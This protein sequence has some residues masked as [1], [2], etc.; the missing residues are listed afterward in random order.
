MKG[1]IIV[2]EGLDCSGKTTA[3]NQVLNFK[4]KINLK[5]QTEPKPNLIYSKGI[6]ADSNF[7]RL[8]R[9]FPSTFIFLLELL[10]NIY[11]RIIS[12]L[13]KGNIVLQDRY[14]ISILSFIPNTTRWYN[15]L[16]IFLV[17]PFIPK[18]NA[19]VYFH[20]PIKHRIKRLKEKAKKYELML[21][22]NPRLITLRE[23]EYLKWYNQFKGPKIK[24]NTEDNNIRETSQLLY[25]FIQRV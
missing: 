21:V 9:R 25:D 22:R 20:L 15:R 2:C 18:P 3:I 7:G 5:A 4:T 24:I 16:L 14:N 6:G 8:A 11:T 17:K 13:R 23:K 10:F 1:K 12:N 19:I